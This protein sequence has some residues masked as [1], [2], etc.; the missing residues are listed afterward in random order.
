MNDD[1]YL[2]PG[3][4]TL[5]NK[6]GLRDAKALDRAERRLVTDRIEEGKLPTGTFNLK[7][8]Q[9][10]HR[11]LFQDVYAWAGEIRTIEIAKGGHQFQFRQYIVTG[12]ADVHRRLLERDFLRALSA[13]DFAN[14]AGEIVGDLN[15]VH[16]FRDGN[17][18]TQLLYLKQLG[19]QA[20]HP[21]D[22]T[23]LDPAAW[24]KASREAFNARYEPMA[25]CIAGAID[26]G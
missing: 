21:I 12:M 25:A 16:P 14:A 5:R 7:H 4:T 20:G 24:L 23:R 8:L 19:L 13:P 11:Y 17:G 3:T 1:P 18:R 6:L 22:L 26:P 2:Y 15:Y 10:I 9:A